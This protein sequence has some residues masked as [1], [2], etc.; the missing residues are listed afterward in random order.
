MLRRT[1][2]Q[3][4]SG[5][6][7]ATALAAGHDL[8]L[9]VDAYSIRAFRWKDM[10]LLDYCAKLGARA[11]MLSWPGDFTSTDAGHVAAFRR[12]AGE[13]DIVVDLAIGSICPSRAPWRRPESPEEYVRSSLRAA[14]AVGSKVVRCFLGS[15][16]DRSG[17]VP[18]AAHVEATSKVLRAVRTEAVDLGV[19]VAV[20]NHGDFEAREMKAMIEDV[21]PDAVGCCLDSGNPLR[22]ME[23]PLQTL[24]VLGPYTV[25]AHMRDSVI[26]AHPRG[27]AFQWVA[28]GDGM[29]DFARFTR[30]YAELCPGAAYHLEI[31]T[32]RPPYIV[33]FLEP[34]FW[35]A[36]PEKRAAEFAPFLALVRNGRP[37]LGAM[38]IGGSGKQPPEYEAAL[39]EQQRVDLERSIAYAQQSLGFRRG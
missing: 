22:V 10:Q 39:N 3:S 34:E 12:R 23:D 28:L 1:F 30:R 25:T 7:A 5:A 24:E 37:F 15:V 32:G 27:A 2:L 19:K 4:I 11:L 6:A 36:F 31:I 9:G 13:L 38:M 17:D 18:F 29:I 20:E 35:K 14:R 21:G 16:E 33:P 26:F 8:R